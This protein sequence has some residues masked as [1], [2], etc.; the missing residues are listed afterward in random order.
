LAHVLR[1]FQA[2][3]LH[4][5]PENIATVLGH[6][7]HPKYNSFRPHLAISSFDPYIAVGRQKHHEPETEVSAEPATA[8]EQMAAKVRTPQGKRYTPGAR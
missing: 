1:R 7:K 4:S 6:G 5:I 3:K 2:A 8:K